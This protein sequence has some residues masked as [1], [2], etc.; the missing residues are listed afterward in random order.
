MDVL[1]NELQ[2]FLF[3]LG[4]DPQCVSEKI[5][6]YM[7]HILHLLPVKNEALLLR[8]YGLFGNK[9]ATLD[10]LSRDYDMDEEAVVQVI[11]SGLRKL[12]VTPEWQMVKQF[13]NANRA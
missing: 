6:H 11:E 4:K 12:A 7:K 3:R 5:E 8:Y 9:R 10:D 1:S 2:D 13:T